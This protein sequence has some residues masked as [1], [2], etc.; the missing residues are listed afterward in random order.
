MNGIGRINA[1][2]DMRKSDR[3]PVAP[4][5]HYYNASLVNATIRDFATDA[6]TMA[7][8]FI[9]AVER[10]GWDFINVGC[11][12]AIEASGL[13]AEMIFEDDSPPHVARPILADTP[14]VEGLKV[15]NPLKDG[16]MPIIVKAVEICRREI[17][18]DVF[19]GAFTNDPMNQ[20]SQLRGVQNFML[21][22][23][24]RPEFVTSLLNFSTDVVTEFGKALIDAGAHAVL[25]GAALCSPNM[26]S[27]DFYREKILP[28]QK[29]QI[30]TLRAHGGDHFLMHIC[31]DVTPIITDIAD[32]GCDHID[33]DWQVDSAA[34]KR[35]L[36][37]RATIRGNLDPAMLFHD[38]PDTIYEACLALVQDTGTD[39]G[40]I[41]GSGCDVMPGTPMEN[42][43][44]MM[45]AA[46]DASAV[47]L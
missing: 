22:T 29:R 2:L 3:V 36:N 23:Y 5:S 39:G 17:G 37:G 4:L 28:C 12:V 6:E 1:A 33:I 43:D 31:G 11:D 8:A 46:I 9:A 38:T 24:D 26:I 42:L 47:E 45:Q 40:F 34:A 41:L 7:A 21:D 14:S 13:G 20:S 27:P 15:P 16:R 35:T 18:D 19:I 25:F 32:S 44:A 30:E 10:F